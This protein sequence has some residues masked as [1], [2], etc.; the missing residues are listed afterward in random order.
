M[1]PIDTQFG[2]DSRKSFTPT[3][4]DTHTHPH[5]HTHTRAHTR[6]RTPTHTHPHT[7]TS[8]IV[9]LRSCPSVP[10]SL[11]LPHI[12]STV[13]A[14]STKHQ[15]SRQ[16]SLYLFTMHRLHPLCSVDNS[17]SI[18]RLCLS[19]PSWLRYE[20]HHS[21][22]HT[23][24]H[25]HT[26]VHTH[27]RASTRTHTHACTHTHTN[28]HTHTPSHIHL[29]DRLTSIL[30]VGASVVVSPHLCLIW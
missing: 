8:W 25:T 29:V 12:Q 14:S 20:V 16:A 17:S 2:V 9:S 3:H 30:S 10:A 5:A 28:T 26:H 24:T 19:A 4:T 1:T 18:P 13:R 15:A 27:T 22:I 6:T 21:P 7:F 23:H 11:F